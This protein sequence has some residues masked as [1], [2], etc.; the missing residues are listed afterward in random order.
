M[1]TA[2]FADLMFAWGHARLGDA[3]QARALTD[4]AVATLMATGDAVHAWAAAG[5]QYRIDQAM[6]GYPHAGGWPMPLVERFDH[7]DDDRGLAPSRRYV[8][9]RLRQWYR[10]V[11]PDRRPDPYVW[12]RQFTPEDVFGQTIDHM[13]TAPDAEGFARHFSRLMSLVGDPAAVE[14][15]A[16]VLTTAA[17]GADRV[18]ADVADTVYRHTFATTEQ[19]LRSTPAAPAE[20]EAV[21]DIMTR[22][23]D[24][25]IVRRDRMFVGKLAARLVDWA[26]FGDRDAGRVTAEAV[27]ASLVPALY[28]L[29]MVQELAELLDAIDETGAPIGESA[30]DADTAT[31]LLLAGCNLWLRRTTPADQVLASVRSVLAA[32][33][34]DRLRPDAIVRLTVAYA[35][36]AGMAPATIGG[37]L[38]L[39]LV[40]LLPAVPN[41]FTTATHF[42]RLHL[43][44][45]EA[46]VLAAVTEGFIP[47]AALAARLGEDEARGRRALL[48]EL[49]SAIVAW[50]SPA[51][52][53]LRA[54]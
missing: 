46:V 49:R 39:E 47:P 38:L 12:H 51:W 6:A 19:F 3:S 9:T 53:L 16:S 26:R 17:N 34:P 30:T 29:D 22:V 28:R 10:I 5:L 40:R 41:G 7:L 48:P 15:L 45:V 23:L 37:P 25:A 18:T 27:F 20:C 43:D 14:R 1:S 35:R 31:Q 4:P 13:E 24:L 11:E 33:A 42:S 32:D 54:R 2:A 8:V 44:V 21:R 52:G 50:A 36:A